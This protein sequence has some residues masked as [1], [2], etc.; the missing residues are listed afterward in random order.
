MGAPGT[1]AEVGPTLRPSSPP[2]TGLECWAQSGSAFDLGLAFSAP[3]AQTWV[4]KAQRH[5]GRPFL[6]P[7]LL[8]P[9]YKLCPVGPEPKAKRKSERWR[10]GPG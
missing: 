1:A 9:G 4:P 3:V 10:V 8:S 7:V 6:L 2:C 5:Q